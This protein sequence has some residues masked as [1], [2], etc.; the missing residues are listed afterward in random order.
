M[1]VNH[2]KPAIKIVLPVQGAVVCVDQGRNNVHL[3]HVECKAHETTLGGIEAREWSKKW[4]DLAHQVREARLA[5][6]SAVVKQRLLAEGYLRIW[7][8]QFLCNLVDEVIL[9]GGGDWACPRQNLVDLIFAVQPLRAQV[10][11]IGVACLLQDL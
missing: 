9:F 7:L 2:V 4:V 8:V 10:R 11:D 5:E 6:D 3:Q 1:G